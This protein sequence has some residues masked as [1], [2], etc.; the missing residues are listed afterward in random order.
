MWVLSQAQSVCI[1]NGGAFTQPNRYRCTIVESNSCT[2]GPPNI[3]SFLSREGRACDWKNV[4][5]TNKCIA[6]YKSGC[7]TSQ[8]SAECTGAGVGFTFS[9]P[10]DYTC[11]YTATSSTPSDTA[12]NTCDILDGMNA[13]KTCVWKKTGDKCTAGWTQAC[14]KDKAASECTG[15]GHTF[16]HLDNGPYTCSEKVQTLSSLTQPTKLAN[17]SR[18]QQSDQCKSNNC[19]GASNDSSAKGGGQGTCRPK[20]VE[21]CSGFMCSAE[22]LADGAICK[23]LKMKYINVKKKTY[24]NV[25]QQIVEKYKQ[26]IVLILYKWE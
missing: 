2:I 10:G 12:A 26:L 15:A 18:C 21:T 1:S 23:K 20:Y 3:R 13:N 17:G 9:E 19:V 4:T 5:G 6:G 25:Y 11:T 14:G 8:A 24:L 7:G 16:T 22:Q